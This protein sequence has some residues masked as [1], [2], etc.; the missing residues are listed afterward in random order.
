MCIK[1]PKAPAVQPSP[2]RDSNASIV[3]D[4]R[5]RASEQQGVYGNIF[6]SALGDVG[7]G[8]NIAMYGGPKKRAA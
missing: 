5:R 2:R 6:T 7:Y 3:Q 8:E 4:N 1:A